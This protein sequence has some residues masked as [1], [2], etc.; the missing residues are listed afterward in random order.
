M[1]FAPSEGVISETFIR[2]HVE[3]LPF[4]TTALFGRKWGI[5]YSGGRKVLPLI[6]AVGM[7]LEVTAPKISRPFLNTFL[8]IFIKLHRADA[9]LVEYGTTAEWLITACR[10]ARIPMYVIFHGFD[11]SVY[12]LLKQHQKKYKEIF[13]HSVGIVAVSKAIRKKL[14][15]M[16]AAPQKT[17][18]NPC[19][20]DPKQF[21]YIDVSKNEIVFLSVGRF[22]EK[23]APFLT[24]LSFYL[25][26]KY[27][28]HAQLRMI[29]DGPLLA[30]CTMLVRALQ[31]E[32]NVTFLG[33]KPPS[34]VIREMRKARAFIQHS[35]I[36]PNGDSEGTPVAIIEAQM[37]GVPV[38]STRHAGI[39]DIVIDGVT[40]H[41]VNENDLQGMSTHI[42]SL[43]HDAEKA[44]SMGR[45]ASEHARQNFS[46]D[47]HINKLAEMIGSK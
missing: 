23:K 19:G 46:L 25:A 32:K 38:I 1:L 40:G 24:I 43:A 26:I 37:T 5:S 39:P 9:I 4:R 28:P 10:I 13:E 22:V 35:V 14:I 7:A 16:G 20:V 8:A 17:F 15:Q 34:E 42:I 27:V 18:W 30:T 41:L 44:A 33:P 3:Q 31:V 6:W 36:A 29:G 11:A 12:S 45:A 2:S 47:A 21:Q